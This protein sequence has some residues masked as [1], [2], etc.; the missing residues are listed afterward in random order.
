MGRV[1]SVVGS[2][3]PR[4]GGP[5]GPVGG[6]VGPTGPSS[7]PPG[8]AG[9]PSA[10]GGVASGVPVGVV[11]PGGWVPAG[12]VPDGGVTGSVPSPAVA[13]GAFGSP[14]PCLATRPTPSPTLASALPIR[15]AYLP[16]VFS[17]TQR[18]ALPTAPRMLSSLS[19]TFL[20]AVSRRS[21]ANCLPCCT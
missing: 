2:V 21:L 20:L 12:R 13:P 4:V 18:A 5:T 14:V 17:S 3:A 11:L 10:C 1:G 9:A 6:S 7:R 16:P 15:S 8:P 19:A